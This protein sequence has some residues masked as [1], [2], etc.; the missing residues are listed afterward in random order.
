MGF[1]EAFSSGFL[2]YGDFKGRACRSEFWYFSLA[3]GLISFLIT[4]IEVQ[5]GMI[6]DLSETGFFN[7]L[8]TAF[9]I[10]PSIAIG[11]RRLHD[12]GLSGWHQ[13]WAITIIGII[14]LLVIFALPA[15]DEE[16][17]WG[18]NPLSY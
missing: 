18:K 14:P 15:K 12:R 5:I 11:A 3:I 17:M 7:K 6:D 9:T 10:I 4:L 8:F 2:K 13:L 1:F 16:N